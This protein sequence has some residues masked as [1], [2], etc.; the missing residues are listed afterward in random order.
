MLRIPSDGFRTAFYCKISTPHV[1]AKTTISLERPWGSRA[2]RVA[3]EPTSKQKNPAPAEEREISNDAFQMINFPRRNL[4]TLYG[5]CESRILIHESWSRRAFLSACFSSTSISVYDLCE[6][7]QLSRQESIVLH[8]S[9]PVASLIYK[10]WTH[11]ILLHSS[12]YFSVLY[13]LY[14]HCVSRSVPFCNR[15]TFWKSLFPIQNA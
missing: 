10:Y 1:I 13:L 11:F 3:R 14:T 15:T 5:F 12:T 8:L 4:G 6:V 9:L 2:R 7:T